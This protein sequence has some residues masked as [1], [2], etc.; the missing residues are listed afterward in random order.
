MRFLG[1]SCPE[2]CESLKF[3]TQFD[4][5]MIDVNKECSKSEIQQLTLMQIERP[6]DNAYW[7]M[8]R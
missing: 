5:K 2:D 7:K 4:S 6:V 1:R 3:N 8:W